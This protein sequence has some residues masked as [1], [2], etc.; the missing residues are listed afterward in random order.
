MYAMAN[1]YLRM[2]SAHLPGE[3]KSKKSKLL[4]KEWSRSAGR[5]KLYFI[6]GKAREASRDWEVA[7]PTSPA[8]NPKV[9][10]L[11]HVTRLPAVACKSGLVFLL[12]MS[13][14][15]SAF[16]TLSGFIFYEPPSVSPLRAPALASCGRSRECSGIGSR[17]MRI[18]NLAEVRLE[19]FNDDLRFYETCEPHSDTTSRSRTQFRDLGPVTGEFLSQTS[20]LFQSW[21][22]NGI[23]YNVGQKIMEIL[24]VEVRRQLLRLQKLHDVSKLKE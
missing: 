17:H 14:S 4:G 11:L 8:D 10:Y 7:F 1:S 18:P 15:P 22:P 13:G 2:Y 23:V 20:S 16:T 19:T 6:T 5:K 12:S 3:Y 24:S 21:R 9:G